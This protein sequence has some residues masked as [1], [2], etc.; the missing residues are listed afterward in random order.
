M[1][2]RYRAWVSNAPLS[3]LLHCTHHLN[4]LYC[5]NHTLPIARSPDKKNM[6]D[7]LDAQL[8]QLELEEEQR[9]EELE[10]EFEERRL[11]IRESFEL[12]RRQSIEM[13]SPPPP[14]PP[15]EVVA[16]E[17]VLPVHISA[18]ESDEPPPPP[19][20]EALPPPPPPEAPPPPPPPPPPAAPPPAAPPPPAD[21]KAKMT[22]WEREQHDQQEAEIERKRA[23]RVQQLDAQREAEMAE[24]RRR[25]EEFRVQDEER[26]R[27]EAAKR[28]EEAAARAAE[29]QALVAKGRAEQAARD[30][31]M[32]AE[33]QRLAAEMDRKKQQAADR[34]AKLTKQTSEDF[35]YE[36]EEGLAPKIKTFQ[37]RGKGGDA[38]ILKIDHANNLIQLEDQHKGLA[39]PEA[40]GELLEETEPCYMLYIHTVK[41]ADGRV[42]YPMC[43]IL[44]MP[45]QLP[46]HLKVMYTRPVVNLANTFR[47]NRHLVLDDPEDLDAAWLNEHLGITV[48]G[49]Q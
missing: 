4:L 30:A 26:E 43:F 28:Q 47:V 34:E 42:Q 39:S 20:P 15:P 12:K 48:H 36:L 17:A 41:H 11:S 27:R 5:T 7:G 49:A 24:A 8:K 10:H 21:G 23:E 25:E 2:R 1:H 29:S 44:F 22:L 45:D 13:A 9:L 33:Q 6:A 16:Q 31:E 37:Q 3:R 40:L 14:P 32:Q 18:W 46:V 35:S 38:M 19:P